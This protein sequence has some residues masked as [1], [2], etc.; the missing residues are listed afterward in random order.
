MGRLC[1]HTLKKGR[2]KVVNCTTILYQKCISRV[3]FTN[4]LHGREKLRIHDS[5]LKISRFQPFA[6]ECY[7]ET[8]QVKTPNNIK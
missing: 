3:I 6:K 5:G 8:I 2:Q 1:S 7:R 4:L